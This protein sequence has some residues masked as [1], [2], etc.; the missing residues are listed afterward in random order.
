MFVILLLDLETSS[1]SILPPSLP[2]SL[3]FSVEKLIFITFGSFSRLALSSH[4]EC[5]SALI[6]L[7]KHMCNCLHV[8]KT[9]LVYMQN[10]PV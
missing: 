6:C 7:Y 3:F 4:F 8:V 5:V 10:V 1:I 2:P 9:C